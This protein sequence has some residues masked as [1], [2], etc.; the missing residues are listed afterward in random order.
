VR[1]N[2]VRVLARAKFDDAKIGEAAGAKRIL[3]DDRFDA[4]TAPAQCQ[5]DASVARN[6]APRDDEVARAQ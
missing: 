4:I 6:L 1:L 5:D 2:V 3:P